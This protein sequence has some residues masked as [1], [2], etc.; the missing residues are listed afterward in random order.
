LLAHIR[1]STRAAGFPTRVLRRDR[2]PGLG[3]LGGILTALEATRAEVVLF[4][5]CDMPFVTPGTLRR[6][7][8]ASGPDSRAVFSARGGVVGF[9]FLIP[10]RA[11]PEVQQALSSRD[12]SLQRLAR[13]L[14]SKRLRIPPGREWELF[15]INTP[16]DLAQA[17]QV[18]RNCRLKGRATFVLPA[19]RVSR[20]AGVKRARDQTALSVAVPGSKL[21]AC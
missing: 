18:W 11:S 13:T 2:V 5:S 20:P 16:N 10:R 6:L 1:A 3:P 15:N 14:K 7:V 9:P 17:M 8:R 12:R 19:G 4:L 21:P